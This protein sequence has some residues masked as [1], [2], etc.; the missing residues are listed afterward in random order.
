MQDCKTIEL[1][2]EELTS[3][4]GGQ[5]AAYYV[6]YVAGSVVSFLDGFAH[7]LGFC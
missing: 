4:V 6:G 7:G 5:S 1:N 2:I 3:I